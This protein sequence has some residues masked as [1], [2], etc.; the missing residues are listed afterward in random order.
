V[1]VLALNATLDNE[2]CV[3]DEVLGWLL[4][5]LVAQLESAVLGHRPTLGMRTAP[6]LCHRESA[7]SLCKVIAKHTHGRVRALPRKVRA[8]ELAEQ[9]KASD[10]WSAES[11]ARR[12]CIRARPLC[13]RRKGCSREGKESQ[14][15]VH[16]VG[17]RGRDSGQVNTWLLHRAAG[18][19]IYVRGHSQ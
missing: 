2:E 8:V 14:G 16:D 6:V 13:R 15:R 9:R 19:L 5:L 17:E 3:A 18:W 4:E 10:E 7:S 11:I 1:E 12:A